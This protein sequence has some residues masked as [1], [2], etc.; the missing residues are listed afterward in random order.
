VIPTPT[1]TDAAQGLEAEAQRLRQHIAEDQA[2]YAAK[3][4]ALARE[5]AEALAMDTDEGDDA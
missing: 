5:T 4:A 2:D 1:I 3:V